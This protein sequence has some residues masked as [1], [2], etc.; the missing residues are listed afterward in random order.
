[1]IKPEAW[2]ELCAALA[3]R[4]VIYSTNGQAVPAVNRLITLRYEEIEAAPSIEVWWDRDE[5]IVEIEVAR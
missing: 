3:A 1:M 4:L 5:E 2:Q